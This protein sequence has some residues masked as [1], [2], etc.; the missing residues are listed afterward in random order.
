MVQPSTQ[1]PTQQPAPQPGRPSGF[2]AAAPAGAAFPQPNI[3]PAAPAQP[4]R[5]ILQI[6][7]PVAASVGQKFSLDVKAG[8]VS[9]LSGAPFVLSFDPVFVEFVSAAEGSFLKKDGAATTF[10]STTDSAGGTVSVVLGRPAGKGGAS[11]GGTL[12]TFVFRAKNK[13]PASF[14]F[15]N[16]AFSAS[17]GRPLTM[18]PFS[19]AM[20]I[21]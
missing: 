7:A 18:L 15:R 1:P 10:S 12:A 17:D 14:G 21:R 8:T 2:P 13:G 9:D 11:G 5:G 3:V 4:Q 19:T 6:S 20:D 16:V